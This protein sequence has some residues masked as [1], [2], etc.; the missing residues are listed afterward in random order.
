MRR[1]RDRVRLCLDFIGPLRMLSWLNSVSSSLVLRLSLLKRCLGLSTGRECSQGRL[2][3]HVVKSEKRVLRLGF[4][5]AQDDTP[6]EQRQTSLL[7]DRLTV[8][9]ETLNL[10]V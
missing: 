8:G 5:F 10:F 4:A 6:E 3:L 1:F 2:S 7:G 9:Q